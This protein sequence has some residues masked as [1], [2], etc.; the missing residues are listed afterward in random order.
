MSF[1]SIVVAL[2]GK[3]TEEAVVRHAIELSKRLGATLSFLH[4]QHPGV[5]KPHMKMD[6]PEAVTESDIR[7]L[8]RAAGYAQEANNLQ[9]NVVK[10]DPY[11]EKIAEATRAAD[12]MI[13]G[14]SQR[15]AFVSALINSVDEKV[16]NVANCPVV[17]V[18]KS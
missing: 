9:V 18:P 3:E 4:V 13:V 14:H 2:A 17:I 1:H 5:G 10:G 6:S 12:L 11:H 7:E 15:N 16:A 8:I